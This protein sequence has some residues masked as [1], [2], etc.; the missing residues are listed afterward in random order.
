MLYQRIYPPRNIP[1]YLKLCQQQHAT[2][3]LQTGNYILCKNYSQLYMWSQV[4]TMLFFKKPLL[5][6]GVIGVSKETFVNIKYAN[7]S[8]CLFSLVSILKIFSVYLWRVSVSNN[9]SVKVQAIFPLI[10]PKQWSGLTLDKLL[11]HKSTQLQLWMES[12]LNL[13]QIL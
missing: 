12:I 10:D 2:T 5:L 6:I 9:W 1:R 13:I 3:G 4:Y 7:V 8:Q 11:Y